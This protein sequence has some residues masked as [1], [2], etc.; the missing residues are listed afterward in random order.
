MPKT[1]AEIQREYAR[2]MRDEYD[3]E[4]TAVWVPRH[5]KKQIRA[6]IKKITEEHIR[7]IKNAMP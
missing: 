7:E 4:Q 2:K 5:R 1:N 3:C 6:D